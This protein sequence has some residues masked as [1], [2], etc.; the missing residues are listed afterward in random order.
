MAN[1]PTEYNDSITGTSGADTIDGLAGNDGING[2]GGDDILD[3]GADDDQLL[4]YDGNDTLIGGAGNDE[5][6][7]GN[8]N[9]TLHGDDGDDTLNGGGGN[10]TLYG[11]SGNDTL[12]SGYGADTYVFAQGDGQDVIH[13]YDDDDSGDI[14]EFTNVASTGVTAVFQGTN[15][16]AAGNSLILQY[17]NGDQLTVDS[18]FATPKYRVG[19]FQ[20]TDTTW[21]VADIAQRHNGTSSADTLQ[22]FD[23]MINK[24][25][26]LAGVDLIVG[27]DSDDT[28]DGGTGADTMIGKAGDDIYVVD[29]VGDVVTE[30]PGQGI[31][32]VQSSV[33]LTLAANVE[34]LTLTGTAAI[35]GTGNG[36]DNTI[37]ANSGSNILDGGTG[38]SD[39]VSFQNATA[40]VTVSLA[41]SAT[42]TTG[43]SGSD[44]VLNFENLTGSDFADSLTGNSGNNVLDGK[45]GA[46][47]LYGGAGNDTYVVDDAGDSV[48][49]ASSAGTDLVQASVSCILGTNV[50]NLTLTGTAAIDGDG[51]SLN[52]TI[53]GN[54]AANT[55][56]GGSGNDTLNGGDGDDTL[57]GS[58]GTDTLYGG[59]GNDTYGVD[60][61]GDSVTENANEGTDQVNCSV[62]FTLGAYIENLTLTSTAAV[63]GTGNGLN[64]VLD[65]NSAANVL[66]GWGGNDTLHGNDGDDT[67]NGNDGDD[68][69]G[70]GAGNDLLYGGAG[71][72]TLSG[73][74]GADTLT[75]QGG[76][77]DT[78]LFG[79]IAG[80]ADTVVGFVSGTDELLLWDGTTALNIG[81]HDHAKDGAVSLAGPGGFGTGAEL[82][83]ITSNASALDPTSAAAAIGS[84]SGNYAV[85]AT[86]LFAVDNGVD[87]ALYLF[88]SA[89]A[90]ALVSA[91]ELTLIVTLQGV[92]QT[93]LADYAFA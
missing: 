71:N 92:A 15:S 88:E 81:D 45:A 90:D 63:D 21:T 23:G 50:E 28:L 13:N 91:A 65:G 12:W 34:N 84:A 74:S 67:L 86:R 42:Q 39:T 16:G 93:A 83:I 79:T 51:N 41:T 87:S 82:V 48:T 3:G 22:G 75:D 55:L 25:Y 70:G 20:F 60:N 8:G 17:G 56:D 61:A 36:L 37:I 26:G 29:N 31:D 62:S 57:W 9:D 11:D 10:N 73:W 80:G 72:D 30:Q 68:Y 54:D 66:T 47:T 27:G 4:G 85:D 1:Y 19:Q 18:Y 58:G 32:T 38:T 14:V 49:E 59:A 40:G 24:I 33:S 52:N 46:D 5:V 35:N 69:L 2:L 7:G 64:N 76:G 77:A 43:G 78:F 53:T 6:Q 44:I 89:G